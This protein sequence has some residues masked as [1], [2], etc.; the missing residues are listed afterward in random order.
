[1]IKKT[2]LSVVFY[3]ITVHFNMNIAFAQETPKPTAIEQ[4]P[5]AIK[6]TIQDGVIRYVNGVRKAKFALEWNPLPVNDDLV[7]SLIQYN[8][9]AHYSIT[10][11]Q[12]NANKNIL[13]SS[14]PQDINI[15]HEA[16]G[17]AGN[18]DCARLKPN[19]SLQDEEIKTLF[20]AEGIKPSEYVSMSQE[21][22]ILKTILQSQGVEYAF[23]IKKEGGIEVPDFSDKNIAWKINIYK[24]KWRNSNLNYYR[25]SIKAIVEPFEKS[26]LFSDEQDKTNIKFHARLKVKNLN[27]QTSIPNEYFYVQKLD[28]TVPA[29][30]SGADEELKKRKSEL[31]TRFSNLEG[32]F[33]IVGGV[34]QLGSV[35]QGFLGGT[36]SS[37]IISGGLVDFSNGGIHPLVGVNQEIGKVGDISTGV[38]VGVGLGEKTS[39]FLGPSIQSS[40]FTISAGATLGAKQQSDLGF[41]GLISVDL[42]RLSGSKTDVNTIPLTSPSVGSSKNIREQIDTYIKS[43][44][45]IQYQASSP[46]KNFEFTLQRVCDEKGKNLQENPLIVKVPIN[47]DKQYVYLPKGVYGYNIPAGLSVSIITQNALEQKIVSTSTVPLQDDN[48]K[49]FRWKISSTPGTPA[50]V[51]AKPTCSPN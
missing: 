34:S 3:A 33:S 9:I 1:M 30:I 18:F 14:N 13:C 37:S 47:S 5:S 44:T 46:T 6:A 4:V 39:I 51:M 26:V 7:N 38:V 20:E 32:I 49:T 17:V 12:N 41:A 16:L 2:L 50:V 36:D 10:I 21:R 35:T 42:S 45:V 43:N 15:I 31:D 19:T 27:Q 25:F 48:A 11:N 40:I 8:K 23:N 28:G 29:Q 24:Y 22:N